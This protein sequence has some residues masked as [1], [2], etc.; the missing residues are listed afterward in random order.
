MHINYDNLEVGDIILCHGKSLYNRFVRWWF[1]T[2]SGHAMLYLGDGHVLD[3]NFRTR[4]VELE[5]IKK[6]FKA[7][8]FYRFPGGLA[9]CRKQKILEESAGRIG[10]FY[11][12]PGAVWHWIK[13]LLR[14]KI[15]KNP[16]DIS[17]WDYCYESVIDIYRS[18]GIILFGSLNPADVSPRLFEERLL[19][20]V[21]GFFD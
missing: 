20:E 18:C 21:V 14:L 3:V 1:G 17:R 4:I 5:E 19:F 10:T 6:Y 7:L 8:R 16:F 13:D 9:D 2:W 15:E 12:I 11:D